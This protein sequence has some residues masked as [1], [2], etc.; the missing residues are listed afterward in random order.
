MV[1]QS[2]PPELEWGQVY[3]EMLFAPVT[4]ADVY[5]LRLGGVYDED[6]REPPFVAGHE[7][8]AVVLKVSRLEAPV[9]S[10]SVMTEAGRHEASSLIVSTRDACK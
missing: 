2:L 10:S 4:P 6:S 1:G 7:G 5:T 3:V 9:H 8:V